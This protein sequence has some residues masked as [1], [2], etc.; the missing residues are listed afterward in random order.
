MFSLNNSLYVHNINLELFGWP[1]I[2]IIKATIGRMN[3]VWNISLVLKLLKSGAF[4]KDEY[5]NYAEMGA[6]RGQRNLAVYG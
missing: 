3:R 4:L 6:F 5:K 1:Y 2:I